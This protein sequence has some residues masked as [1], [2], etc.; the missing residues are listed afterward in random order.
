MARVEIPK[1]TR[2]LSLKVRLEHMERGTGT[3]GVITRTIFRTF[4]KRSNSTVYQRL[5][6]D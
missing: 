3:M 6:N 4:T 5:A 1:L 2:K